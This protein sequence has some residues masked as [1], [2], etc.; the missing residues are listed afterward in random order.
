M[1]AVGGRPPILVLTLLA[2]S[3]AGGPRLSNAAWVA[4]GPEGG[5]C[6]QVAVDPAAPQTVYAACGGSIF[7]STD[8]GASWSL[9]GLSGRFSLG[10]LAVD[11][12]TPGRLYA[13]TLSELFKS[14]DGGH[15]WDGGD[16]DLFGIWASNAHSLAASTP[17]VAVLGTSS[18]VFSSLDA[19]ETW[20]W[21]TGEPFGYV[22]SLAISE[23]SPSTVYAGTDNGLYR[24]AVTGGFVNKGL[25]LYDI[26][27]VAVPRTT[28]TRV[29]AGTTDGRIFRSIDSG[30]TW[31]NVSTGIPVNATVF[32]IHWSPSDIN[33]LYAA[34]A[35]GL[36]ATTNGTAP[37]ID[38]SAGLAGRRVY[39]VAASPTPP[40]STVYAGLSDYGIFKSTN[41]AASWA[42]ANSGLF[43][44]RVTAI[45]I[46][47]DDTAHIFVAV[48]GGLFES[49]DRGATWTS[50]GVGT[51]INDVAADPSLAG[52][53]YAADAVTGLFK[54]TDD[55]AS[56]A[57]SGSGLGSVRVNVIGID[58]SD[59]DVVYAGTNIGVYKS[60]TAGASWIY[61]GPT[62]RDVR[63]LT[64][65]P[66][67]P[68]TLYAGLQHGYGVYKSSDGGA[69]WAQINNG[70]STTDVRC[71]GID[72]ED[73]AI[74][75]AG[76]TVGP[77]KSTDGGA[78]WTLFREGMTG[79]PE[80]LLV[81]PADSNTLYAGTLFGVYVSTDGA[82]TWIA[83]NEG[84]T[85]P[86]IK[87]L[88]IDE[89]VPPRVY[90][91]ADAG[92]V[93]VADTSCGDGVVDAGEGC[94]DGAR[95]S[96]D[97]CSPGCA[98]EDG[99]ACQGEPSVCVAFT[100]T[101][102][103]TATDTP[104]AT[105]TESATDTPTPTDTATPSETPS[106]TST[107]TPTVTATASDTPTATPTPSVTPTAVCGNG[108]V[109]MG[110]ACDDG[111]ANGTGGSCC[112]AGCQRKPNGAT[113]CDG[114]D[115]TRSDVCTDGVCSAGPCATGNAC[116][117]CGGVCAEAP[118][119]CGCAF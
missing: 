89:A 44:T 33:D 15:G 64:V 109:E 45:E 62:T 115:C 63:A 43:A 20:T 52:V 14:E 68:T 94:D 77:Y 39:S 12:A 6:L 114:N 1:G 25:S 51:R 55:G 23:A 41:A 48:D 9:T 57:S 60:V 95:Y 3:L 75:Y 4:I 13:A 93:F 73:P 22:F 34:T 46:D 106:A 90:A 18:G 49:S 97:G 102:T 69:S 78:S 28:S 96:G 118:A 84:L 65:D 2:T 31:T 83:L 71:M 117:I 88:A 110:E 10:N 21:V 5:S 80:S 85:S 42:P 91:G 113:S 47:P 59:S 108:V 54:S 53:W 17:A 8:A 29:M 11:P 38:V 24:G 36:F 30:T 16:L 103:P 101:P 107:A 111:D 72:A 40:S 26:Y 119:G 76:T 100:P 61:V 67:T 70:I 32:H 27:A 105:P 98:V 81:D 56:W 58:P 82:A 104:S 116:G 86:R 50:R 99:F 35:D 37:W 79:Y 87:A 112:T 74:V 92:G 19:G 7:K 66:L